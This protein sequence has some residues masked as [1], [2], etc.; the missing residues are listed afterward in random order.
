MKFILI[1]NDLK[2]VQSSQEAGIDR[3]M[4]DLEVL[5]KRERQQGRDTFISD[6]VM[7]DISKV[8][9][10]LKN[11]ELMVRVNPINNLSSEEINEVIDRGA[12]IVMLPMFK[13][14]HEVSKF[15]EI[16]NKRARI[17]LLLETSEA[18]NNIE[19][20]IK[21]TGIN[22]IHIGLNDLHLSMKKKFLFQ[23]LSEGQVEKLS[24]IF[25]RESIDF[26]FGGISKLGHGLLDSSLILSEHYRLN[27][28]MVIL[29]RD[30]KKIDSPS[31]YKYELQRIKDYLSILERSSSD[32]L[33]S[34][35]IKLINKVEEIVGSN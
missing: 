7:S 33:E 20:I 19:K 21:N 25:N 31:D 8:K 32:T 26:G 28:K 9:K 34:N 35:K 6:H 4:I 27:S 14:S 23:L 3:I 1:T 29:S 22:E 5:G 18:F 11:T 16:I 2:E 17:C 30:F 15:I 24:Q 13:E 12:D 10:V